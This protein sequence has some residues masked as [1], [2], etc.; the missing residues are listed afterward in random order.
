M[1]DGALF[2]SLAHGYYRYTDLAPARVAAVRALG[3][4]QENRMLVLRLLVEHEWLTMFC[5]FVLTGGDVRYKQTAIGPRFKRLRVEG[6]IRLVS[7]RQPR[8]GAETSNVVSAFVITD[9]GRRYIEA[10]G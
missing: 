8:A 1:T 4:V 6:L 3:T 5:P 10:A 7:S 2:E 9:A